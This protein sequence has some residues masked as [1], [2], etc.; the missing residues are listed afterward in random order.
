MAVVHTYG[1]K[2]MRKYTLLPPSSD[3]DLDEFSF[4]SRIGGLV[5]II[6]DEKGVNSCLVGETELIL[7]QK[8][9]ITYKYEY[10]E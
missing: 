8:K 1:A 3:N 5:L 6:D 9:Q 7:C 10:K 2:T 4:L